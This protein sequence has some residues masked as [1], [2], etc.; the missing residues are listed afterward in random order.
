MQQVGTQHHSKNSVSTEKSLDS[1]I[2]EKSELHVDTE[3]PINVDIV[4]TTQ[5]SEKIED[6]EITWL[7][8][9]GQLK[10]LVNEVKE[11]DFLLDKIKNETFPNPVLVFN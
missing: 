8:C 2:I 7:T 9:A 10:L 4:K 1:T 5:N 6:E 11:C 3:L